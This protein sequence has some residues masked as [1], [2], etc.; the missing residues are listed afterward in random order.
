MC[1][2]NASRKHHST[3]I[4]PPHYKTHLFPLVLQTYYPQKPRHRSR[5]A[6][7]ECQHLQRIFSKKMEQPPS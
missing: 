5:R 7:G 4:K 3:D 6:K 1:V 2:Y